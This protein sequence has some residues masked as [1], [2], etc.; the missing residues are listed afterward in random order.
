MYFAFR[1]E[2]DAPA[3]NETKWFLKHISQNK[4]NCYCVTLSDH[5]FSIKPVRSKVLPCHKQKTTLERVVFC[6]VNTSAGGL[7]IMYEAAGGWISFHM[8]RRVKFH[9]GKKGIISL[10]LFLS[11]RIHLSKSRIY[12]F[13]PTCHLLSTPPVFVITLY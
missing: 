6:L 1:Q 2:T 8:M 4:N 9:N 10:K 7:R 3:A 12:H 5:E 13:L 11:V